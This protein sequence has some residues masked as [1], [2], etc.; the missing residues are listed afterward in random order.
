MNHF[1]CWVLSSGSV[2]CD[3]PLA[4][5]RAGRELCR[6]CDHCESLTDTDWTGTGGTT[7]QYS[8]YTPLHI[9]LTQHS[10]PSSNTFSVGSRLRERSSRRT[11]LDCVK[12]RG[13]G[14]DQPSIWPSERVLARWCTG[15]VYTYRNL[16]SGQVVRVVQETQTATPSLYTTHQ[17]SGSWGSWSIIS[18]AWDQ[19]FR[20]TGLCVSMTHKDSPY[21]LQTFLPRKNFKL[22]TVSLIIYLIVPTL[23]YPFRVRH[24]MVGC[25]V[26]VPSLGSLNGTLS[27]QYWNN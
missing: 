3:G 7:V 6:E 2:R 16:Y 4:S 23:L 10:S 12:V 26:L 19:E 15:E 22:Q 8:L 27:G 14:E 24:Y 18:Q 5:L 21:T 9:M 11:V 1:L 25:S 20:L 13:W 17:L